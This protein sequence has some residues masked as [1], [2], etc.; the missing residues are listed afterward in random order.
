MKKLQLTLDDLKVKS[1]CTAQD[2]EQQIKVQGASGGPD[3]CTRYWLCT[4]DAWETCSIG[5]QHECF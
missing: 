1:F 3:I 4:V 5:T 2:N